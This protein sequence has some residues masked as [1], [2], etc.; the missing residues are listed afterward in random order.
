MASLVRTILAGILGSPVLLHPRETQYNAGLISVV[1][2]E[3]IVDCDGS[4]VVSVDLRGVFVGNFEVQ[5]TLDGVNYMLIPMRGINSA[6]KNYVSFMN[7]AGA[8]I[9]SCAGFRKVRIRC[10]AY[11]SG[12][13]AVTLEANVGALDFNIDGSITP[14]AVTNTGAAGA[15]VTLSLP[16]PGL[17]LRQYLTFLQIDRI[18]SAALTAAAAPVLVTTT[19]LP[20]ALVFAIPADAALQGTIFPW[21]EKWSYAVAASAQNAAVTIVCPATVGVIWRLNAGYYVGP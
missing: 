17:G 4:G 7:A 15:A 9:G 5:G 2:G 20:G 13:A 10:T 21:R 18:A 1:N 12:S 14:L 16:T 11:T 8:W 3:L 6:V 19:N